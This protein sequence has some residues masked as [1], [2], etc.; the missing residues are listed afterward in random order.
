MS[1][2][3]HPEKYSF[4]KS[5]PVA[6]HTETPYTMADKPQNDGTW[7]I[8]NRNHVPIGSFDHR[9]FAHRVVKACNHHEELVE[10]CNK[11]WC[12]THTKGKGLSLITGKEDGTNR[13]VFTP[14]NLNEI[15][16][17]FSEVLSRIEK[18][19]K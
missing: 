17:I 12:I 11:A 13:V 10:A 9:I 2:K 1:T 14:D 19:G 16:R 18:D 5:T 6:Q 3:Q 7:V 8:Y 15:G 4:E